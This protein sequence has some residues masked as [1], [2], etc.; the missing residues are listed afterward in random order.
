MAANIVPF[1]YVEYPKPRAFPG[2][3]FD[4]FYEAGLADDPYASVVRV[5]VVHDSD[6][7]EMRRTIRK[8]L[9]PREAEGLIWFLDDHDWDAAFLIDGRD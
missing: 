7:A 2:K 9:A 1:M 3:M 6:R 8:R 5:R 4:I